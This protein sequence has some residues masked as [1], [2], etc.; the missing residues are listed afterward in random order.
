MFT[1]NVRGVATIVVIF[2]IATFADS[3]GNPKITVS[4]STV[5]VSVVG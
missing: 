2:P 5:A 3:G 1:A 4:G